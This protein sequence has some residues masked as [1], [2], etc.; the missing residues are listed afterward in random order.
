MKDNPTVDDLFKA[1]KIFNEIE[2]PTLEE[3][4]AFERY[5]Q[6]SFEN[7]KNNY[8]KERQRRHDDAVA[9]IQEM[10]DRLFNACDE[11]Y[12]PPVTICTQQIVDS[13]EDDIYKTVIGYGVDVDR[14]ELIRALTYDREQYKQGYHAGVVRA[15][16]LLRAM[17]QKFEM[18]RTMKDELEY[19]FRYILDE[20]RDVR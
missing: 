19:I 18:S 13:V 6:K 3:S 14:N 8:R 15:V 7:C 1:N 5:L 17:I 4:Q 12:M 9:S 11:L 16:N 2:P 20:A 10:T